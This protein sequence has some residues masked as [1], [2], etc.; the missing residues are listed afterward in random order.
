MKKIFSA[1]LMTI[2]LLT[3]ATALA[4]FKETIPEGADLGA[5]KRL[6]IAWPQHY[7]V[8]DT[9]P[10]DEEYA[11]LLYEAS[12]VARCYV[13]SYDEI[14]AQ[15]KKDTGIDIKT[16]ERREARKVFEENV[17][18]YADAYFVAT[19]A[20]NNR[21]TQFFYAVYKPGDNSLIYEYTSQVGMAG[22]SA[23]D[24]RRDAE[25]FYKQFD[26]TAIKVTKEA[27]KKAR[28]NR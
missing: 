8:E 1:L 16:L 28:K 13:A 2:F 15:I 24:Y 6:A 21:N 20:N 9:E 3:S 7:K 22:K 11:Q 4:A 14:A 10:T 12:K 26:L 25:S 17:G 27:A 19:T 23:K 18:K 5:V